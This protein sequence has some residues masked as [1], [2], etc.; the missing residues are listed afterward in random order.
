MRVSSSTATTPAAELTRN[1]GPSPI[2]AMLMPAM[3]GP[4][5]A[6]VWNTVELRLIALRRLSPP[7]TSTTNACRAGLSG[8]VASPSTNALSRMCHG[9]TSPV[10]TSSPIASAEAAK[11]DC[12][13]L[14]IVRL[15]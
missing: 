13:I 14:R 5:S 12:V 3:A 1:E 9:C 6:P 15:L 7:A 8:T 10:I 4:I 11:I 2:A